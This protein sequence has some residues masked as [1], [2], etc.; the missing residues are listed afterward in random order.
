ML[1]LIIGCQQT[2]IGQDE[3]IIPA[4]DRIAESELDGQLK[5]ARDAL[6]K[7]STE[8]MR[9][10]AAT[11]LLLAENPLAR[12][13]LL[14]ALNRTANGTAQAAV[15]KALSQAGAAQKPIIG[16]DDFIQP[17]LAILRAE[18]F[19]RA[20][21]AAEATLLFDYGQISA[22]LEKIARDA[23][24]PAKARLN[25]IYALRLQPDMKAAIELIN[26]AGDQDQEVAAAAK[27]TLKSLGI[28]VGKDAEARKRT[29]DRLRREGQE[30]FLRNRL[31]RQE[32]QMREMK[33]QLSL[34]QVRY[35]SA[36]GEIYDAKTGDTDK[37]K[38]LAEHLASPEKIV[39]LWALEKVEQLRIGTNKLPEEFEPILVN[40]VGDKDRDVR[41]QTAKLLSLM[42]EL[43]SAE[44]LLER[45]EIEPYDDVRTEVFVALGEAVSYASS[46]GSPVK[47][48]PQVR[49]RTLELAS[50]YLADQEPRKA[51]EGAEVIRKLL[52]QK[53]LKGL[54]S[55]EVDDY[56]DRLKNRYK[57]EQAKADGTLRG[58]LLAAMAGLCAQGDYKA[59]AQKLYGSLFEEALG[60]VSD[61]VRE[62]AVDGL[63]RI[64][65]TRALRLLRKDFVNDPSVVV[66]RKLIV[67]AGEV[68]GTSDL[69]WL[70]KKIGS[71]GEGDLAWQAMLSIFRGSGCD[72]SVLDSWV[73]K[74]ASG[75][76]GG[77]LSDERMISLLKIAETKA[78]SDNKLEMLKRMREKLAELYERSS[79]FKEAAD[80]YGVLYQAAE[81]S[82]EKEGIL[83]S[84][85]NVHLQWPNV[86]GAAQL[87]NNY[88][89][90]KDLDP[91]SAVAFSIDSYFS[92]PPVGADPDAVLAAL[93]KINIPDTRPMW[94]KQ[95]KRWTKLLE[96]PENP[97]KPG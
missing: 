88:L 11:V 16:R 57:Q 63:I 41:L 77:K 40:L 31:I 87:V 85:L 72:A 94:Q 58:A 36:L 33:G 4:D 92:H 91:N 27:E 82:G 83:V 15:C 38:F 96:R 80:Y 9:V 48:L 76:N 79:R 45:H 46:A 12:K 19:A 18:D 7:G 39:K 25:S 73:G 54:T 52:E 65:K 32:A 28:P 21:L 66:R 55:A 10:S 20:K 59:Q 47:I 84:L 3:P 2:G 81:S 17:L 89:L 97:N 75:N 30:A 61:L 34:W 78:E 93:G 43:N 60:D 64:D 26:L 42:G 22:G 90:V 37:S 71:T 14:E 74:F 6:Y 1:V 69:D 13:I 67:L 35:R 49:K 50:E 53:G 62:A 68:G 44:K 70:V 23:S 56:L 29:I 24:L 51:R 86:E 95:V 8:E 5:L